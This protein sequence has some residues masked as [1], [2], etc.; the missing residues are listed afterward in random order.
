MFPMC[1]TLLLVIFPPMKRSMALAL[2]SMVTVVAPIVGPIT[3]GW[4]TDNYSR[5]WIFYVQRAD[6]DFR[7]HRGLVAAAHA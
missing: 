7:L 6:W 5:P 3:G 1:Q 4:L 2:L